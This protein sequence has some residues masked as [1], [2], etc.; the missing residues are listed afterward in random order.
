MKIRG[1]DGL[2]HSRNIYLASVYKRTKQVNFKTTKIVD[3]VSINKSMI[4][5]TSKVTL[6]FESLFLVFGD[7]SMV[8]FPSCL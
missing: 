8:C 7:L 1:N 2:L 3:L 5:P 4:M 6:F